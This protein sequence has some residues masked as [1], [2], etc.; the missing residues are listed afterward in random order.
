MPGKR[1]WR[2][3]APWV[4]NERDELAAALPGAFVAEAVP[5]AAAPLQ[6]AGT[7]P[8]RG[9]D[10]ARDHGAGAPGAEAQA[11]QEQAGRLRLPRAVPEAGQGHRVDHA[12]AAGRAD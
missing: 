8:S 7:A 11:Q 4:P 5:P 2:S 6:C 1:S 3:N 9:Q 12:E 10:D